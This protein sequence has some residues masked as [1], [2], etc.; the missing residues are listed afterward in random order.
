MAQIVEDG[1]EIGFGSK[2]FKNKTEELVDDA[3][4]GAPEF[5]SVNS[6]DYYLNDEAGFGDP[7]LN[8]DME[9]LTENGSLFLPDDEIF[10]SLGFKMISTP[11]SVLNPP[12]DEPFIFLSLS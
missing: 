7:F 6:N 9:I 4:F 5:I 11:L 2:R 1:V 10:A 3:G 8:I 12:W